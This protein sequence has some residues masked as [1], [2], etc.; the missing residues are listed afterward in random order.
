MHL[1]HKWNSDSVSYEPRPRAVIILEDDSDLSF[2]SHR[3]A[4]DGSIVVTTW[5]TI[6]D[7]PA[8]WQWLLED[9]LYDFSYSDEQRLR[10]LFTRKYRITVVYT[11][12]AADEDEAVELLQQD[13]VDL[14]V[15]EG[16]VM[17]ISE[18]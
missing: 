2:A 6:E 12:E 10:G 3:H 14:D 4:G 9:D 15:F 7:D 13:G 16:Y 17:D 11:V 5:D 1:I 8:S 18:Q